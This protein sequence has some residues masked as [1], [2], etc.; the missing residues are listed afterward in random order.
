MF[1]TK[2]IVWPNKYY[3]KKFCPKMLCTK[4]HFGAKKSLTK[5]HP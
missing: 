5:G 3:V 4:K 1:E 2:K